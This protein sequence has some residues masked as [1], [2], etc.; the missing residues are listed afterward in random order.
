MVI[1]QMNPKSI[2]LLRSVEHN[3]VYNNY[4]N[5]KYTNITIPKLTITAIPTIDKQNNSDD[6]RITYLNKSNELVTVITT[7]HQHYKSCIDRTEYKPKFCLWCRDKIEKPLGIPIKMVIYNNNVVFYVD[8]CSYCSPECVYAEIRCEN[9]K[10]I[11]NIHYIDSETLLHIMCKFM[12]IEEVKPAPDW[13]LLDINGGPLTKDE[14]KRTT[15][16]PT[17]NVIQLPIKML[18]IQ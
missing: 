14:F 7:N 6:E 15:Y 11:R 2:F 9:M 5:G 13:W 4:I 18:Y 17:C 10:N 12:D 16:K 3:N 8:R 1:S